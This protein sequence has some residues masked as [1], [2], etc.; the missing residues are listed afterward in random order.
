MKKK[1]VWL[2]LIVILVVLAAAGGYIYT[3]Y[4]KWNTPWGK[5]DETFI[6]NVQ[7]GWS[8]RQIADEL[9]DKGIIDNTEIFL[10]IA[11]LRGIGDK[12]KA[13]EYEFDGT[14]TPYE[15]LN[16]LAIGWNRRRPLV[17]P[18]GYTQPQIA[19]ACEDLEICSQ[20]DLFKEFNQVSMFSSVVSP[21]DGKTNPGLEGVLFPDTYYYI[22]NTPPVKI[23]DR[24]LKRFNEKFNP[25]TDE[26]VKAGKTWWWQQD[27]TRESE[28]VHRIVIMASIIERE[29]K[30]DEDRPLVASVFVNRLKK[31]M[32]LQA[33]A[34]VHYAI[35]D[36]TRPL[37]STDLQINSPY[38]T[39]K[40][41]GLPPAAICNP[42]EE[43]LRAA[44]MPPETDYLY[45]VTMADGKARFTADYNE[46]LQFKR[47]YKQ[48]RRDIREKMANDTA[49][50]PAADTTQ[51]ATTP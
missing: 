33:D 10:I 12:L 7:E 25:I 32:P 47:E 38:N 24:F 49:D 20:E 31:N 45:Y 29:V 30:H 3:E 15:V 28:S 39:Y 1:L 51:P 44:A 2:I 23:V 34:T 19:K 21:P 41:A 27:D 36:W 50:E 5:E 8:A 22:K 4:S 43:A 18:E 13:G 11:D 37:T 46:F 35:G 26:A 40:N 42:G 16:L 14:Q 9:R 6:I 17:I 48:E